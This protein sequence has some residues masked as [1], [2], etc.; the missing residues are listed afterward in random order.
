MCPC[1][2]HEHLGAG[3][4]LCLLTSTLYAWHAG[5]PG[6][7]WRRS[8]VWGLEPAVLQPCSHLGGLHARIDL[9]LKSVGIAGVLWMVWWCHPSSVLCTATGGCTRGGIA[10]VGPVW[11]VWWCHPSRVLCNA[12]GRCARGWYSVQGGR[13]SR[14]ARVLCVAVLDGWGFSRQACSVQQAGAVAE[15]F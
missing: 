4:C 9:P 1:T 13:A 5:L 12:T 2:T 10:G 8:C 14:G 7:R 3:H 11:M 6:L 15:L